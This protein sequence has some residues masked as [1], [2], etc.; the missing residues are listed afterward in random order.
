METQAYFENIR[1]HIK[2]RLTDAEYSIDLAVAWFTD[3]VL[4][5]ALCRKAKSGVKVRL[6]FTR[7]GHR[8]D[9]PVVFFFGSIDERTPVRAE[10]DRA[11]LSRRVSDP[12]GHLAIDAADEYL[13][14]KNKRKLFTVR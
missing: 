5:D 12:L 6:L 8:V 3:R 1:D 11:F 9:V 7:E 13:T 4:F 10:A 14:A 2:V